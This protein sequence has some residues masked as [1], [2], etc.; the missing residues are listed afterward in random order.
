MNA[1]QRIMDLLEL[2]EGEDFFNERAKHLEH[3]R[4]LIKDELIV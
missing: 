4:L 2:Y 1:K 3:S